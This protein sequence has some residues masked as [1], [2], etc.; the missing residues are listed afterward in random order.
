MENTGACAFP[1]RSKLRQIRELWLG[2]WA[3]PHLFHWFSIQAEDSAV[4]G[5]D[6]DLR[7][8]GV[9]NKVPTEATIL[10]IYARAVALLIA[11]DK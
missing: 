9:T 5:L 6:E 10:G 1:F 11:A 4:S 2:S 7:Q 3:W 8:P